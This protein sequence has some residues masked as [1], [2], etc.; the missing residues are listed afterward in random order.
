MRSLVCGLVVLVGEFSSIRPGA[1]HGLDEGYAR[2]LSESRQIRHNPVDPT[3]SCVELKGLRRR[4]S[5][6]GA[7]FGLHLE[8]GR[9]GSRDV[10][11]VADPGR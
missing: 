9:V 3:A 4:V 2:Q 1:A 10:F 11:G 5:P 6:D 7:L 8:Y